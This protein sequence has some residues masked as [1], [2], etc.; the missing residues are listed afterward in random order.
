MTNPKATLKCLEEV[1]FPVSLPEV[2]ATE[3][4]EIWSH[5]EI[6]QALADADPFGHQSAPPVHRACLWRC[7]LGFRCLQPVRNPHRCHLCRLGQYVLFDPPPPSLQRHSSH[8]VYRRCLI[9]VYS[10]LADLNVHNILSCFRDTGRDSMV[11]FPHE[12]LCHTY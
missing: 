6:Q 2:T 9:C 12:S 3:L 8:P 4:G 1:K 11:H 7:A 5:W 10:S